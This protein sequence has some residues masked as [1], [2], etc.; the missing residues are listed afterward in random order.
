M[1]VAQV[2]PQI[3]W[4]NTI[5]GNSY[6]NLTSMIQTTDD[7]ILLEELQN[8][9]YPAINPKPVPVMIIGS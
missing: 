5:G 2:A 7:G 3:E 8:R 4:E 9:V 6:D 1:A